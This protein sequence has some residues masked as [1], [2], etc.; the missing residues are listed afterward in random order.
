MASQLWG[1]IA[2]KASQ[3]A[4]ERGEWAGAPV[5][6]SGLTLTIAP[7]YGLESDLRGLDRS[8]ISEDGEEPEEKPHKDHGI[9]HVNEWWSWQEQA[10]VYVY[11]ENGKRRGLVD[12]LE[13]TFLHRFHRL[14]AAIEVTTVQDAAA[15]QT[16]VEKL[17]TLL[18]R[19]LWEMY[20]LQGCFL[21]TSPKSRVTYLF[22]KGRPTLALSANG[23]KSMTVLC[24]LCM[25]PL[26]YYEDSFCGAIVPTDEVISHLLL[27][28]ADEH[29]FWRTAN[30][31]PPH[32]WQCG[33]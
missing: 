29:R 5:P 25:H 27:M 15:E 32:A 10:T 21:E 30:Q 22:R 14:M 26:G 7:R 17:G 19:H 6:I 9:T 1:E 11:E 28:R 24:G 3:L 4:T 23:R 12:R 18:P 33:L 31:H 2:H 16:A 20:V 13:N 8:R